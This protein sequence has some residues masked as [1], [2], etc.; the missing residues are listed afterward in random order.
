M[1][2]RK[3]AYSKQLD[4]LL[5][6]S[7][8]PAPSQANEYYTIRNREER[9]IAAGV[10]WKSRL[11]PARMRFFISVDEQYQG[12][13]YGT[14][15]FRRMQEE[16]AG[17]KWQGSA[18]FE[19]DGAEWWLRGM[20]FE[21]SYRTYWLDCLA[22]DLEESGRY[23]LDIRSL[24]E[25]SPEQ[26]LMVF[27]MAWTDYVKKHEAH[28]P[29]N[30]AISPDGF[31]EHVLGDLD[32]GAGCCLMRGGQIDAYLLCG[33]GDGEWSVSVKQTGRRMESGEAYRQF[34]QEAVNR[35]FERTGGLM[36]EAQSFDEDAIALL[37]LFGDLPED[38][39][40]TY[41]LG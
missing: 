7:D 25:L 21:F 10:C 28:D 30:A 11:H 24:K 29:L 27:S 19:N 17:E 16:H 36:T 1:D 9:L 38:S 14:M 4:L 2:I 34:L 12:R 41:T 40:D 26:L 32:M 15:L 20:G 5:W 22:A 6:R 3:E 18:D 13:G 8:V 23:D 39:Y 31:L 35:L 33:P 37:R